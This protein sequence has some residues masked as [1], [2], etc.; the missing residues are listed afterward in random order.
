MHQRH[1]AGNEELPTRGGADTKRC[2]REVMSKKSPREFSLNG[3][4][5][6]GS[7]PIKLEKDCA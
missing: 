2:Q 3:S 5:G 6:L 7:L 1:D 4:F